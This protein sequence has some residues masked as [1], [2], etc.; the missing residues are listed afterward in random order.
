MRRAWWQTTH[1]AALG[2]PTC[3]VYGADIYQHKLRLIDENAKSLGLNNIH[4]ILQDGT[5][6]GH[7]F[8]ER[9]D[10]VLVDAP[11]S[12]LGVLRHKIDLRWRKIRKILQPCRIYS[13]ASLKVQQP[14]F[15]LAASSCTVRVP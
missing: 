1:L 14:A 3:A 2:G 9:A 13:C 5:E 11:C 8:P 12:G 7:A 15:V 10:R 6:I 4:P